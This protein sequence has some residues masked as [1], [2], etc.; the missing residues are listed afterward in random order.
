ML[1]TATLKRPW[2]EAV[3]LADMGDGFILGHPWTWDVS[4]GEGWY[5][6]QLIG[7]L[8]KLRAAGIPIGSFKPAHYPDGFLGRSAEL[9]SL[10]ERLSS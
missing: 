3:L 4:Y 5:A 2:F 1:R 8:S 10:H 9:N 6:E 7:W